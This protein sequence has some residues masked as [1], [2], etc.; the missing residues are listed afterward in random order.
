MSDIKTGTVIFFSNKK[1]FGFIGVPGE[2]DIFVH[3]SDIKSEGYRTLAKGVQ[4][5][6]EI[7]LNKRGE[8]KAIN[9]ELLKQ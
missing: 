7:G 4:V 8:P 2:K 1:G 6:F 9:V 5:Q 3:Y